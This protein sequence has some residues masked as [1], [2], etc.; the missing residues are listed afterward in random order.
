[1][2]KRQAAPMVGAISLVSA[3]VPGFRPQRN[4]R[5]DPAMVIAFPQSVCGFDFVCFVGGGKSLAC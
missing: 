5:A 2:R 1:M 3:S 4:V